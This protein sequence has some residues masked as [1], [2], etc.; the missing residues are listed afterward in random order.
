MSLG[1]AKSSSE[2]VD[3]LRPSPLAKFKLNQCGIR[4]IDFVRHCEELGHSLAG[5]TQTCEPPGLGPSCASDSNWA[6]CGTGHFLRYAA[7]GGVRIA[8]AGV[9]ALVLPSIVLIK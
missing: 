1:V 6:G 5:Q 7:T 2:R 9:L 3:R 4:C 8:V